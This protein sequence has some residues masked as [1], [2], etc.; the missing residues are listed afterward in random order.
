V[1]QAIEDGVG[2]GRIAD[3]VVPVIDG[4]LARDDGGSL[5]IAILDDLQE[6]AALLVA[7]L[8]RP[9]VVEDEQVGSGG[10]LEDLG[11]ASVAVRESTGGEQPGQAMIGDGEVLAAC[12]VSGCAGKLAL[13][14][15]GWPDQ[16]ETVMLPD[17]VA[18]GELQEQIA[19]K[20]AGG[21]EVDVLDL[22]VMAEPCRAGCRLEALLAARRR[23]ALQKKSEPFAM[24]EAPR[25]RLGLE[26][27]IGARHAGEA[28]FAR[29]VDGGIGQHG[30]GP[31]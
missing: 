1:N 14:D 7:E 10:C 30:L 6:I 4:H 3:H 20:A 15:A 27:V 22:G 18:S 28:E 26:L 8:L 17:P 25:F 24:L 31:Q 13:A 5:L 29:H 9:P 16:Q 21:A 23:L 11:I 2:E 12:L 19:V